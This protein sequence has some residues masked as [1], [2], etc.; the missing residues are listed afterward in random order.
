M[1]KKLL[2]EKK[3]VRKVMA[4]S[5]PPVTFLLNLLFNHYTCTVE[6]VFHIHVHMCLVPS[7][8]IWVT[9]FHRSK[10]EEK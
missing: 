2:R 9:I 3:L 10:R 7:S 5:Q 4:I 1:E 6:L 8:H